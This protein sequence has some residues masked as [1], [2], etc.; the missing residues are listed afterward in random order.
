MCM[1]LLPWETSKSAS[2]LIPTQCLYMKTFSCS[3]FLTCLNTAL[4]RPQCLLMH[5]WSV[6]ILFL[7]ADCP[8]YCVGSLFFF[9]LLLTYRHSLQI[10]E[11]CLLSVIYV[12]NS[13]QLCH[14]PF[15][16]VYS[17]V[18]HAENCYFHVIWFTRFHLLWLLGLE[19]SWPWPNYQIRSLH[20]CLCEVVSSRESADGC[21]SENT[22]WSQTDPATLASSWNHSVIL[23]KMGPS[24][25]NSYIL[26]S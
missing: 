3:A 16:F 24:T 20:A 15:V 18:S 21:S 25:G 12:P 10:K 6:W 1:F 14:W 4:L 9:F 22:L 8:L 13:S 2:F 23:E 11:I 19:S 5:F 17:V 7:L 26:W